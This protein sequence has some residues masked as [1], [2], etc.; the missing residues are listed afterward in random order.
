MSPEAAPPFGR[1]MSSRSKRGYGSSAPARS[2]RRA[3]TTAV[4]PTLFGPTSTLRPGTNSSV[5]FSSRRKFRTVSLL[6]Y[7]YL[8]YDESNLVVPVK[9]ASTDIDSQW[10]LFPLLSV[11]G[12][13]PRPYPPQKG[14]GEAS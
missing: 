9:A 4:L 3:S 11:G 8:P 1:W 5:T 6:R 2:A 14:E 12:Y 13:A 7:M 10:A